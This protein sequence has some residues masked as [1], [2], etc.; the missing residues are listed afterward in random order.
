MNDPISLVHLTQDK[1]GLRL[2]NLLGDDGHSD[3]EHAFSDKGWRNS[4][5]NEQVL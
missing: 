3:Q 5:S 2:N 4:G 1:G